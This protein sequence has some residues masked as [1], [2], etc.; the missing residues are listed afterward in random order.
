MEISAAPGTLSNFFER[1]LTLIFAKPGTSNANGL[2]HCR[3]TQFLGNESTIN[4]T[5]R[6]AHFRIT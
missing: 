3:P 1:K 6:R 2:P 5:Q 4:I